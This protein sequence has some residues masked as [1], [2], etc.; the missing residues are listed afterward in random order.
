MPRSSPIAGFSLSNET[1]EAVL[2]IHGFKQQQGVNYNETYT[3]V[4]RFETIRAAIY[5]AVQRGWDVLQYDVKTAFL[6]G[7]LEELIF[8]EQP[9]GFQV[10]GQN[11]IY[12]VLE[13][14]YGL[15]Q[16]PN[17]WNIHDMQS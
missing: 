8:M 12:R 2:V 10:D 11:Y 3:P 14:L 9:P 17:I 5:F 7:D 4:I 13:S 15:K 1:S 16:A 6:Y